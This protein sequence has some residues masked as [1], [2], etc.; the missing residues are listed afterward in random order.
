MVNNVALENRIIPYKMLIKALSTTQELVERILPEKGMPS[1]RIG[2]EK[3]I[4]VLN[5]HV[6][7]ARKGLPVIGYHFALPAEYLQCFECVPVCLEGVGYFLATLLLHGVEKYYD[8]I[9]NYGHPFHTCSA[10]K[11]SMGM[12]LDDLFAFDAI[13]TPTAPCDSTCA[14]YPWFHYRKK[15]PLIIADLPFHYDNKGYSY[16]ADQLK[17]S[18]NKLGNVIGQEPDFNKLKNAINIENQVLKYKLEL[19][20]LIKAIPSPIENMFN[21]ISAGTSILIPGTQEN[22][23]F[24]KEMLELAKKRYKKKQHHGGEEKI[25][26]IWPYMLTFFDISLCEWLDRDIGMSILF[27]I[28]NYNFFDPIDTKSDLN[29]LFYGMSKKGMGWPMVKQ[30]IEFYYPFIEDCV[31][32]AKDFSADC[33]IFT[34]SLAC[35]QFGAIPQLLREFLMEEVGIPMLII[36]FDVGDERFNSL[37]AI[38]NKIEMFAQS[39]L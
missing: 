38:K 20:E 5:R 3:I 2:V 28:F 39:L 4:S 10:Q 30:S 29:T 18:L 27:D 23:L 24:Y 9:G 21:A 31:K 25:R 14:S 8:L 36:E 6:E 26:S 33:F 35:K 7:Q 13:I 34:Q 11:G 1:L 32:M 22:L 19:F 17:I 12:T 15:F 37:K 16:Y